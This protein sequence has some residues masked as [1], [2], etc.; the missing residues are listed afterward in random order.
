[1]YGMHAVEKST[2]S[3]PVEKKELTSRSRR[4]RGPADIVK[5]IENMAPENNA[6]SKSTNVAAAVGGGLA[7]L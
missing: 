5:V 6:R 7:R 3:P 1:M 2:R 4:Q